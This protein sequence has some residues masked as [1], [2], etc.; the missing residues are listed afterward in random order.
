VFHLDDVVQEIA[1]ERFGE[2]DS[3]DSDFGMPSN[4]WRVHFSDGKEPLSK[5][6][7]NVEE[8]RLVRCPHQ[9][10]ETTIVPSRSIMEPEF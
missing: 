10:D 5:Y 7:K 3:S 8:L 4:M 2:L 9:P 6:F 1:T